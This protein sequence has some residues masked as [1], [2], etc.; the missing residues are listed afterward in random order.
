MNDLINGVVR[1]LKLKLLAIQDVYS[2]ETDYMIRFLDDNNLR[3]GKE[4]IEKYIEYLKTYIRQ[5]PRGNKKFAPRTINKRIACIKNRLK[6]IFDNMPPEYQD[7]VSEYKFKK[8]L[9]TFKYVKLNSVAVDKERI[10][11]DKEIEKL[12]DNADTRL[13]LMIRFLADTGVRVGELVNILVGDCVKK[14][15]HIEVG[16]IGKGEKYRAVMID[17]ELFNRIS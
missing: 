3:F 1:D 13:S 9:N 4:G 8:Y 14:K 7:R 2:K 12:I 10:L 16:I 17:F 15:D 5:T 11:T 6:Y